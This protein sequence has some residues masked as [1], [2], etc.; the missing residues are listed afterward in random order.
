MGGIR[1][2]LEMGK[3]PHCLGSVLFGFYDYQG[4]FGSGSCQ[5]C[6]KRVRF[7]SFKNEGS[8]WVG[9]YSHLYF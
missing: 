4:S 5:V 3:N 2:V 8:V 7:G 1:E 6:K 9:F